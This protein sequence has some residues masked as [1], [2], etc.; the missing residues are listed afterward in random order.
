[1]PQIVYD[2]IRL[3]SP[4]I[5]ARSDRFLEFFITQDMT[6]DENLIAIAGNMM[7][8]LQSKKQ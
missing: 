8:S 4:E 6:F 1:M 3:V 2:E 7:G 5:L